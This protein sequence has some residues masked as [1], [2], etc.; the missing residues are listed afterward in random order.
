MTETRDLLI[1]IGTEELPPKALRHLAAAFADA[2]HD[3]LVRRN[4]SHGSYQ[5]YA[6]PRR[7]AVIVTELLV[8][9]QDEEVV[10]RGPALSAA[11]DQSGA[12]TRAAQGFARACGV[13]LEELDTQK[14]DQGEWLSYRSIVEGKRTVELLP[15]VTNQAL[16]A[17]PIPKRMRWGDNDMEF[18]RPVHW[19]VMIFGTDKVPCSILGVEAENKT[20][21]HRFHHPEP[22]ELNSAAE[23]VSACWNPVALSPISRNA[24]TVSGFWRTALPENAAGRS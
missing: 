8:E 3:G 15:E 11:Y 5:W 1:E 20:R 24:R 13:K 19:L 17:I 23:Y 4:L 9:Q 2:V 10:R 21:G 7:L 14:T 22:L 12:P 18:I 16:T 6:S